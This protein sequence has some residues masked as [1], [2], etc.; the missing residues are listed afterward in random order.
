MNN[1]NQKSEQHPFSKCVKSAIWWQEALCYCPPKQYWTILF[2]WN[3][4]LKCR[5]YMLGTSFLPHYKMKWNWWFTSTGKSWVIE[6][7]FPRFVKRAVRLSLDRMWRHFFFFFAYTKISGVFCP[8]PGSS[9]SLST[10]ARS[11]Q[12]ELPNCEKYRKLKIHCLTISGNCSSVF[13]YQI[14]SWSLSP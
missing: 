6:T 5:R 12:I 7:P 4:R 9:Y 13:K 3:I 8:T 1:K 11:G 14:F 2:S 10:R